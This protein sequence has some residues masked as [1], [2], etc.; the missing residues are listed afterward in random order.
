M[1]ISEQKASTIRAALTQL[2]PANEKHWTDDGL[3]REGVVRQF[4]G[5]QSISRKEIQDA[6]PGFQRQATKPP[7]EVDPLTGEPAP[8][9]DA[10]KAAAHLMAPPEGT[11]L[12]L[13]DPAQ[14]TGEYMSDEE[15][16]IVLEQRVKD[17]EQGIVDAQA[18]VRAANQ[19]VIDAQAKLKLVKDD[20]TREFPPLTQAQNIKQYIASEMAQRASQHG[21]GQPGIAPGSQIDA[22]MQRSNSRGWRRPSRNGQV[23][24]GAARVA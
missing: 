13:D 21:H 8:I 19:G 7:L 6:Y 10:A 1:P 15:V 22:A 20:L 18:N 5:D 3:P 14:N 24:T 23:Q 4:A 2:D 11:G 12:G 16:R 9:S 17:A